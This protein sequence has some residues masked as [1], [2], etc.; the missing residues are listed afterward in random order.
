LFSLLWTISPQ[1]CKRHNSC[2]Y[3]TTSDSKQWIKL[4]TGSAA[5]DED[6]AEKEE[7]EDATANPGTKRYKYKKY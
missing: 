3:Q 7:E 5:E 4:D 1:E 2:K 6:E